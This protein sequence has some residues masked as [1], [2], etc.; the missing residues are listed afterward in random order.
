MVPDKIRATP[1]GGGHYTKIGGI[2]TLKHEISPPK[3]YE[4][5]IKKELKGD[6]ALDLKNFFK[7][8]KMSLN[9]VTRLREYLLPDYQST[10]INSDFE[11]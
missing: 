7:H 11:E 4:I 1:L 9:A 10:K 6:T 5:L 8:I 2:W 3:F